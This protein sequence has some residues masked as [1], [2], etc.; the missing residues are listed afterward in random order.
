MRFIKKFIM[1][2]AE[3]KAATTPYIRRDIK[4]E[5]PVKKSFD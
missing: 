2:L 1:E 5:S 3:V 4:R